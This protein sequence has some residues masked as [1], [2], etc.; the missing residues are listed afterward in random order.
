MQQTSQTV[1]DRGCLSSRRIDMKLC[2]Q[3]IVYGLYAN[4]NVIIK[5]WWQFFFIF[6]WKQEASNNK[7]EEHNQSA[8]SSTPQMCLIVFIRLH[9]LLVKMSKKKKMDGSKS[10]LSGFHLDQCPILPPSFV[11]ICLIVVVFLNPAHKQ[12][13]T[14]TLFNMSPLYLKMFECTTLQCHILGFF[15]CNVFC[16]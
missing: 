7:L 14:T 11:K 2:V 12:T 10:T 8:P 1:T 3:I 9:E 5:C 15:L 4:N 16:S 13:N 6:S